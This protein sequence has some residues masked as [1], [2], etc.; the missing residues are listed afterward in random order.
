M[1]FWTI[2]SVFVAIPVCTDGRLVE[3]YANDDFTT[4]D[5]YSLPRLPRFTGFAIVDFPASGMGLISLE[6]KT[7]LWFRGP[8]GGA[9]I[10]QAE[11]DR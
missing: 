3:I 9:S 10:P 7:D 1:H 8:G 4:H 11:V 2:R 6:P 5:E